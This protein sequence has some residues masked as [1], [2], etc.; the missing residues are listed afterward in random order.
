MEKFLKLPSVRPDLREILAFIIII[1]ILG[2][3]R[4]RNTLILC[5]PLPFSPP[6]LFFLTNILPPKE[7]FVLFSYPVLL[8]SFYKPHQLCYFYQVLQNASIVL[9][10]LTCQLCCCSCWNP[11][12]IS[13]LLQARVSIIYTKCGCCRPRELAQLR[14]AWGL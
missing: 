12:C 3:D 6:P 5:L 2:E 1:I 7:R 14:L 13:E 8:S 11:S 9:K 10:I 4:E